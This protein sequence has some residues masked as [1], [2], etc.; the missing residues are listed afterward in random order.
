ML[1]GLQGS[2]AVVALAAFWGEAQQLK[3][4]MGAL[5]A[6]CPAAV[7]LCWGCRCS[8]CRHAGTREEA[9]VGSSQHGMVR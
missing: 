2:A 7:P 8:T 5:G 1:G 4:G 3:L 9:A 6:A